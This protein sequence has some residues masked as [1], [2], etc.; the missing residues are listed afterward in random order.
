MWLGWRRGRGGSY[1]GGK[2]GGAILGSE[3]AKSENLDH[4][5]ATS[6]RTHTP[7]DKYH[8]VHKYMDIVTWRE[9]GQG[10]GR[11]VEDEVKGWGAR[12]GG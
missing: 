3:T 9:R 4:G 7:Q 8:T 2:G 5:R 12:G 6:A 1:G 10:R 11:A